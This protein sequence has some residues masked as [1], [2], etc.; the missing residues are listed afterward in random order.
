M[1]SCYSN[2]LFHDNYRAICFF[3][4]AEHVSMGE[5]FIVIIGT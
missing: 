4:K 3:V 1:F 5:H 2:E